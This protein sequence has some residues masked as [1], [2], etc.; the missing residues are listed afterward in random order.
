MSQPWKD[1][2]SPAS[3]ASRSP[4]ALR[5]QSERI[6]AGDGPQAPAEVLDRRAPPEPVAAVDAVDDEPGLQHECV[7]DHRIVLGVGVLLDVEVLLD[8]PL[9][10]GEEWPLGADRRAEFLERVMG[11]G[12]DRDDLRVGHRDLRVESGELQVLLVL[13]RAVVAARERED[14]GIVA[15]QLAE[16]SGTFV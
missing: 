15:L 6:I 11:V 3:H 14:Q 7:L 10:V 16:P 8:D 5:A 2:R 9:R 12:R 1:E 13:L 4:G